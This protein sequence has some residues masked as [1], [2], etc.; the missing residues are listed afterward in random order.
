MAD[1]EDRR[2]RPAEVADHL[3]VTSNE[4]N[5]WLAGDQGDDWP[6]PDG[7]DEGGPWWN[8]H[9]LSSWSTWYEEG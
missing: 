2:W 1:Y 9:S 6:K 5:E 3:G 7:T 8:I 4:F